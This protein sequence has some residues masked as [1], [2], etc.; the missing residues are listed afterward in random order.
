MTYLKRIKRKNPLIHNMTNYVGMNDVANSL[1]AIGASPFMA[2]EIEEVAEINTF[3]DGLVLNIGTLN[4]ERLKSMLVAGKSANDNQV[5][6]VLDPVGVGSTNFR[7]KSTN[8]IL[9]AIDIDLL[10]GNAGEIANFAEVDWQMRGVDAGEGDLPVEAVIEVANKFGSLVA[11]SGETD[12]ITNGQKV[13]YI[14]N[15][16]EMLSQITGTGDVLS[17]ICGAF[18]SVAE[19]ENEALEAIVEAHILVGLAGEKAYQITKNKGTGSFRVAL[20]DNLNTLTDK[21]IEKNKKVRVD[22]DV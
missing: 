11:V 1:I 9:D 19:D 6:V 10:R 5:P 12:I 15:G 14:N 3:S 13:Y 22:G 20:I 17:A 16:N 4:R 2:D 21:E 8:K 18:L 7:K